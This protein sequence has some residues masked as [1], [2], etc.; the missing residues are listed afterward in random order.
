MPK[1]LFLLFSLIAILLIGGTAFS[2]LYTP[3]IEREEVT[4]TLPQ[5]QYLD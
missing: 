4:I 5:D 3:D 2:L 1:L